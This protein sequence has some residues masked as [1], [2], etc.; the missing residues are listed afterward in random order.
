MSPTSLPPQ[1]CDIAISGYEMKSQVNMTSQKGITNEPSAMDH[2]DHKEK[3][4]EALI[5]F[6]KS[7]K[8]AILNAYYTTNQYLSVFQVLNDISFPKERIAI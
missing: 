4:P 5:E 6:L 3:V 7:S 1:E 8:S 2:R